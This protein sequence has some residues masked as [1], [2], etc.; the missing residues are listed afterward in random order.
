MTTTFRIG[1]TVRLRRDPMNRTAAIGEYKVIRLL[2]Y[3]GGDVQY[4]IK[5]A[6]EPHERVVKGSSLERA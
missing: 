6:L 1:Q 5:S 3:S 2:P 4:R